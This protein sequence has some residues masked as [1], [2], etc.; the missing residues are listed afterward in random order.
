MKISLATDIAQCKLAAFLVLAFQV[1]RHYRQALS[2]I[3]AI[4]N[5]EIGCLDPRV[6][7]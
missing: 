6:A 3:P 5:P 7:D 2:G 4:A 1:N